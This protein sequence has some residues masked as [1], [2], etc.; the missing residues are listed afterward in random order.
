MVNEGKMFIFFYV[1]GYVI[2]QDNYD[3]FQLLLREERKSTNSEKWLLP[4]D[5]GPVEV[6]PAPESVATYSVNGPRLMITH[7]ENYFFKSYA[8]TQIIGPFHKSFT[9]IVGPNGSGK[10]NVIDSMLFVFGY[11]AN[12]IRSKKI[13]VLIHSS[14]QY[15]N[16]ESCT[17]SVH[18]RKS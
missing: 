6:P 15:P 8:N 5:F 14:Q 2:I 1:I 16:V 11:R 3:C 9:S 12:K 10:S 18:F 4:E 17:V 13:S 7:I